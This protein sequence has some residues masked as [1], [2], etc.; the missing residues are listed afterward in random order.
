M[1]SHGFSLVE[2]VV[3]IVIIGIIAAIAVPRMSNAVAG[4]RES[5]LKADLRA[6]RTAIDLYAIEHDGSPPDGSSRDQDVH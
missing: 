1:R 6:L 2:L 4:A 3:V 5:V